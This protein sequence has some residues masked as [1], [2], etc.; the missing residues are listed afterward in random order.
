MYLRHAVN[1]YELAS[2]QASAFS[3]HPRYL[4]NTREMCST[5]AGVSAMK[6]GTELYMS[7]CVHASAGRACAH[8]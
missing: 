4:E 2:C 7:L 1:L 6:T 3:V 8:R 5:T